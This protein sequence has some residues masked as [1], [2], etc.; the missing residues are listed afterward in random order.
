MI[1][2]IFAALPWIAIGVAIAVVIANFSKKK[3]SRSVSEKP[4]K[5]SIDNTETNKKHTE[6]DYISYGMSI[7][8][9]IGVSI[10][11]A[12]MGTY[13]DIALTYGICFGMLGGVVVG[14][15]IKKK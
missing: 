5:L 4:N 13:G 1:D 15:C 9:C 11:T 14:A 12:L 2:F 3:K 7:G 10:G 8:M 6:D